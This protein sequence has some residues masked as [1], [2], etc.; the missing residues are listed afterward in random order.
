MQ[1][2]TSRSWKRRKVS[3]IPTEPAVSKEF[4]A[5]V[6]SKL[7]FVWMSPLMSVSMTE[8][9]VNASAAAEYVVLI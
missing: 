4:G 3:S 6:W 1:L 8:N 2:P 5:G 9:I 7:F